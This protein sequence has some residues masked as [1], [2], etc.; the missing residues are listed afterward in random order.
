[1]LILGK[2]ILEISLLPLL[3]PEELLALRA[4]CR[5]LNNLVL[6]SNV[7]KQ[8]YFRDF[9]P[10][11]YEDSTLWSE[12]YIRRRA[13]KVF[14]WGI[15]AN[16]GDGEG[17]ASR[18]T[19]LRGVD[20]PVKDVVCTPGFV[21]VQDSANELWQVSFPSK[22]D[23]SPAKP[24]TQ[25]TSQGVSK[26]VSMHCSY[27]EI[28]ACDFK[29][30][31]HLWSCVDGSSSS[32]NM[33]YKV[34]PNMVAMCALTTL[35]LFYS[36]QVGLVLTSVLS[37]KSGSDVKCAV[38][39]KTGGSGMEEIVDLAMGVGSKRTFASS[40]FIVHVD[41]A[42]ELFVSSIPFEDLNHSHIE[43]L[44]GIVTTQFPFYDRVAGPK[45]R[46]VKVFAECNRFV[47]LTDN[48]RA[49][50][51]NLVDG[52]I[53][54]E[55]G[56][57]IVPDLH[58]VVDV[59]LGFGHSVALTSEGEMKTWGCDSAHSGCFGLGTD[60]ELAQ[61]GARF[62]KGTFSDREILDMPHTVKCSPAVRVHASLASTVALG[63]T[64]YDED[65]EE[66]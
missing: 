17:V 52:N 35:K 48:G 65:D 42:G 20:H 33:P 37:N 55:I 9:G 19:L 50:E 15:Y 49:L 47:A 27:F 26:F 4:T 58:N 11:P 14:F 36:P 7:W 21:V 13:A 45:T 66:A 2:N 61:A 23:G 53:F 25:L 54:G 38:V 32:F 10:T 59:A 29:G 56:M 51:I 30:R 24:A 63:L 8:L 16:D 1:M 34:S 5:E 46:F 60:E 41:R 12:L 28:M 62:E 39:P 64:S 6:A 40:Q 57:R 18:P 43:S 22:S 44:Q 3:E 31:W